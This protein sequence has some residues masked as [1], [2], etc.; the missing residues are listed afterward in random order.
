MSS[1][2]ILE[3]PPAAT[4]QDAGRFGL[5][6][7]SIP[8]SGP[9]DPETHAAANRAVGNEEGATAIEI[10]L[11]RLRIRALAEVVVSLDGRAP[12]RL[13]LEE[14]LVVEPGPS[15]VRYLALAGGIDVP[16]VLGSRSTLLT[17]RLGGLQGR[18]LRRGDRLSLLPRTEPRP[19]PG[20][21]E[22]PP[23][24]PDPAPLSVLPGPHLPRL[25]RPALELLLAAEWQVGRIGDRVGLR[26]DGPKVP[27]DSLDL[28]GPVPMVRGAVQ[29]TTDGTP[30]VL[31]PDHPATGGY[32]VVLVLARSA[33]ARL[34]RLRPGRA[35]RFVLEDAR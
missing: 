25:A 19:L 9:L 10:P 29:L 35:L 28:A 33:Q 26:L 16:L 3:A 22:L 2:E 7:R 31:G 23:P 13:G 24:L 14:E 15:A 34:A 27:R 20:S 12:E 1:I 21:V 11:G 18:P 5:L 17:A 30:I 4:L 8:P 6:S 32:P